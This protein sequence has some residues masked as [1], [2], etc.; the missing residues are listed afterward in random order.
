MFNGGMKDRE[1]IVVQGARQHNLKNITVRIPRHALT[2][3]T[4]LSGSGKSSLAFDTLYAEGQRRYVESLSVY[5]R[6][7]LDQL[8]KPDV[9]AIEGLSPAVAIEQRSG[10]SNPRSTVATTTEIH[11]YLRLVFAAIGRRHCPSCG[12]PVVRQNAEQVVQTLLAL[13]AGAKIQLLAPL[14]RDFKGDGKAA[15]ALVRRKGFTRVRLD[16]KIQELD[17]APGLDPK[18]KH[19]L[20]LVVD[21]VVIGE[22]VRSRLADSVELTLR[23]GEGQMSA[24]AEQP[25]G[26]WSETVFSEKNAC[27][28][29]GLRFDELKPSH[30]SFN[31]PYGACPECLGLGTRLLFDESVIVP[32]PALSLQAGAIQAW[33]RGGRRLIIYYNGLLRA[34]AKHFG[35]SLDTPYRELPAKI[36][37]LLMQGSDDETITFGRWKGAAWS[38]HKKGFEGVIPNLARRFAETDSETTRE[39]LRRYMVRQPCHGCEGRRLKPETLACL[40]RGASIAEIAEKSVRD[41]LAFFE[42]LT[43]SATEAV[44]VSEPVREIR[45]RLGFLDKVGL[46]YLTLERESA[47]LSGGEAQRIRLATQIGSG[48]T[49]VLYVLDE[50]SIGLHARDQERLLNMLFALRDLGNTLVIVEHDESTIRQ[51]DYLIDLGPGAGRLGGELLAQ[52]PPAE[53]LAHP[54][55]LTGQYLNGNKRIPVPAARRRPGPDAL[56]IVGAAEHNLR[57]IDVR[58]P[59]GLFVC[60]TGV[61]G[62][63]KSTLVDDI[64]RKALARR[65]YGSRERPGAHERIEGLEKIDKLVVIDPSPIGRTP[66][67]NPVT[68]TGAYVDIRT[69]FASLPAAKVRGY[70]PGRFSFNVKGGRCEAC[71]GDGSL[72]LEMQFLPEVY[73]VC[74]ACGGRRFNRETLEIRYRGKT[75]AD[76][77]AMTVD[78]A[79]VFFEAIPRVARKLKTL[80]EVGLGYLGLG[81]S[82][83]T[84]SGG[85]AQRV[86]L[87]AELSRQATGKTLYLMDEPTT[88]LHAADVD[89][90]LRVLTRLRDGG[91]TVVVIE[92]HL[93]VIKSADYIID[94]GPEGGVHGG[95]LTACGTPEEVASSTAS[96]TGAALRSVLNHV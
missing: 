86:K 13:P 33:K 16:G 72:K 53:V 19:S 8:Q 44:M 85:E 56:T 71:R 27:P 81:Q 25:D 10:G 48:L 34:L 50:P 66:R 67:S 14:A 2:V 52:G 55:S 45:A 20:D 9:D 36:R 57:G 38:R 90:L 83:T 74:E 61:S 40:L 79:L 26:S 6:Q 32:D 24:L 75:I 4:G 17:A 5:A 73:V 39:G 15:L 59:L 65:L 41:A 30:F 64:L 22:N 77:L 54:R 21:R 96:F 82:A 35:F 93:D 95:R 84:L 46:D 80:S 12:K 23:E 91:N 18:K 31:S 60:V 88:G 51:A 28:D 87:S 94:L 78:E 37:R 29:C 68:Y 7:F 89:S 1:W 76:V 47:T 49:G 58:I 43:L 92:H 70:G 62:S 3:I 11:D 69:L 42:S 63:G